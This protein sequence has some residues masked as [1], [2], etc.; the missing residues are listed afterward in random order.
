MKVKMTHNEYHDFLAANASRLYTEEGYTMADYKRDADSVEVL[1]FDLA[2]YRDR[3]SDSAIQVINALLNTERTSRL[4]N[5]LLEGHGDDDF[6]RLLAYKLDCDLVCDKFYNGFYKNDNALCVLEFCEGDVYLILCETEEAYRAEVASSNKF[7]GVETEAAE[8]TFKEGS[9]NCYF[10]GKFECKAYNEKEV[11]SYILY[12]AELYPEAA[13][14]ITQD[15]MNGYNESSLDVSLS[16]FDRLRDRL[17]YAEDNAC[18]QVY[19]DGVHMDN[20]Y[21][22]VD[23]ADEAISSL[24]Q[25]GYDNYNGDVKADWERDGG[26]PNPDISFKVVEYPQKSIG[27]KLA[28]AEARSA[29]TDAGE[30]GKEELVKG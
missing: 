25:H 22:P 13:L 24:V 6:I 20:V 5:L 11:E 8:K 27:E 21:V 30:I 15:V 29:E 12:C 26:R 7:Y 1:S 3:L 14:R 17:P 23:K 4:G 18:V 28:N 10:D 16:F 9:Y 19:F 2:P